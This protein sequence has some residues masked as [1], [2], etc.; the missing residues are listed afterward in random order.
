MVGL[1]PGYCARQG[2]IYCGS[3]ASKFDT[4]SDITDSY[5]R[6]AR[7]LRPYSYLSTFMYWSRS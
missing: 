1:N 5:S 2:C 3:K 4:E 6:P 7:T